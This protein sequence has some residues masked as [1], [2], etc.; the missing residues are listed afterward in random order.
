MQKKLVIIMMGMFITHGAVSAVVNNT[1]GVPPIPTTA[2]PVNTEETVPN[3]EGMTELEV[4]KTLRDDI[5]TLDAEIEKCNRK[6]KGWVATTVV[7]GV[8]VLGTGIAAIVQNKQLKNKKAELNTLNAEIQ[9]TDT[10]IQ[11]Q[12]NKLNEMNNPQQ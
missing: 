5:A 8:G 3:S 4:I 9:S 2:Q 10:Q 1:Y 6:R 7:G 12:Q 11:Q